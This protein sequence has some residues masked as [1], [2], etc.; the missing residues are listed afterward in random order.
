M[1]IPS[2][3]LLVGYGLLFSFSIP[4]FLPFHHFFFP[5]LVRPFML[6]S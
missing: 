2:P 3:S 1:V 6:D 5:K 4:S